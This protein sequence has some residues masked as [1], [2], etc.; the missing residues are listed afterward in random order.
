MNTS[1]YLNSSDFAPNMFPSS[2][3]FIFSSSS[4]SMTHKKMSKQTMLAM[5][6]LGIALP[7]CFLV[8]VVS[9]KMKNKKYGVPLALGL[10][11][12][13]VA[14]GLSANEL[15]KKQSNKNSSTLDEDQQLLMAVVSINAVA[16]LIMGFLMVG[17]VNKNATDNPAAKYPENDKH[18]I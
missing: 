12:S 17:L 14:L 2:S 18:K 3:E 13:I 7:V 10:V 8:V 5:N 9:L 6:I 15:S 1:S 4:T 16:I 11:F